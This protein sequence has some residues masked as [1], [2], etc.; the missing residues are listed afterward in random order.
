M[1]DRIDLAFGERV[2]YLGTF[3]WVDRKDD[4]HVTLCSSVFGETEKQ[5]GHRRGPRRQGD[6]P[7]AGHVKKLDQE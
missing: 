4:G 1:A 6:S 5:P 2:P 3:L 7:L